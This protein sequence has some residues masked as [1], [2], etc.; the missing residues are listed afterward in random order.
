MLELERL[1]AL[2][3][4]ELAEVSALVMA[5]HVTLE[6]VDVGE[7]FVA[8]ATVLRGRGVEGEVLVQLAAEEK[9]LLAFRTLESDWFVSVAH[10]HVV[11]QQ[12][13]RWERFAAVDTLKHKLL[14]W[15][16]TV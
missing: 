9:C 16:N 8:H 13:G 15:S 12:C 14:F 7:G 5:D 11:L 6:T 3:T 2:L 10:F 1:P 4:L